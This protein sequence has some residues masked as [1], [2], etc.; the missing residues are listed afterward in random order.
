MP[1]AEKQPGVGP[2]Q[3]SI[4]LAGVG[5]LVYDKAVA[6]EVVLQ[7]FPLKVVGGFAK[8][9]SLHGGFVLVFPPVAFK[10]M[11]HC[12][13]CGF[14]VFPHVVCHWNVSVVQWV[15]LQGGCPYPFS[16]LSVL[17]SCV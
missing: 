15:R 1:V 8:L 3:F 16:C 14:Q 17:L 2:L 5:R 11:W 9:V 4:F 10:C 13:W 7:L 6:P 12:W